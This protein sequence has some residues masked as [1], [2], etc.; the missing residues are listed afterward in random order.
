MTLKLF[1]T[2]LHSASPI[3]IIIAKAQFTLKKMHLTNVELYTKALTFALIFLAK[4][5]TL[6]SD[7]FSV[8]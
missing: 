4:F 2:L 3:N 5:Q 8:V 1:Q 6:N 7:Y